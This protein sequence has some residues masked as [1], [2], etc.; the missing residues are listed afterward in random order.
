M[1]FYTAQKSWW[2]RLSEGKREKEEEE[3]TP[4]L[5]DLHFCRKK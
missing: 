3:E 4:A 5:T 2:G 1:P